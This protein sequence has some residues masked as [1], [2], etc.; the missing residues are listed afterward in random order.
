MPETTILESAASPVSAPV[1]PSLESEVAARLDAVAEGYR[2]APL[3]KA[4]LD[5]RAVRELAREHRTLQ[6]LCTGFSSQLAVL[7]QQGDREIAR[8]YQ[9]FE[10]LLQRLRLFEEAL[11]ISEVFAQ[12]EQR[13]QAEITEVKEATLALAKQILPYNL[14][15]FEQGLEMFQDRCDAVAD[16]LDALENQGHDIRDLVAHYERWLAHLETFME[17]LDERTEALKPKA[18]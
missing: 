8:L 10:P 17:V 3:P 6:D 11:R 2:Q 15:K 7:D 14:P 12:L 16:Q 5:A 18:A 9:N 13:L 1:A 4:S